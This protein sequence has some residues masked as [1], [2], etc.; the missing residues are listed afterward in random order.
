ML[1]PYS[2]LSPPS[3]CTQ[4]YQ[5]QFWTESF[6][7]WSPLGNYI[8]TMHRQGAATWGGPKWER[9][10]RFAHP[11]LRLIDYSTNEKYLMTYSSQEPAHPRDS[12]T[13]CFNIFD[14]RSGRKLRVFEGN[15]DEYAVGTS[16][17]GAL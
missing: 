14:T 6:V 10:Q 9:L 1:T 2:D 16:A 3:S 12:V 17:S 15:A 13:V 8:T 5:R 4:V 11:N 7:Q